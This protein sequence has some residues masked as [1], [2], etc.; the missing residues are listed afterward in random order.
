MGPEPLG[1]RERK[2][3]RTR[4]ALSA[5]AIEL[6]LE[7]GFDNVSV[8]EI[9][10]A[11]EVSKPT[12]FAYFDS[13]E[14]L[15]LHRI[16]DHR[17]EAGRVVRERPGGESALVALENHLLAGLARRDPV[18][19]LNDDREVLAFHGM[20][21]A[22]R[23]LAGRLAQ[24]A[25]RDEE[26]LAAALAETVPRAGQLDAALV[27]A[28]VGAVRRVLARENWRQLAAGRPAQ[29]VLPAAVTAARRAFQALRTGHP[30]FA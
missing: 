30:D 9:A 20:V 7:R 22:T 21:F 10:A 2:K 11:A 19:G 8:A 24:Y 23:S 3:R 15:V 18:T 6:F 16:A 1:L 12:L 13:K 14:D 26:E 4:D 5:A 25:A 27:A 17:G 28:Q 29:E